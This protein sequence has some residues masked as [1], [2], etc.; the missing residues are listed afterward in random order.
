MNSLDPIKIDEI[1]AFMSSNNIDAQR[2][3]NC[4]VAFY[5]MI[6]N[7]LFYWRLKNSNFKEIIKEQVYLS[8]R[9]FYLL[10]IKML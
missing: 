4:H 6:N 5:K 3:M 9:K 1:F 7:E 10:K 2:Y 8:N